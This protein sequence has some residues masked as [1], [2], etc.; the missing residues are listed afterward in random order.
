MR[1]FF[2]RTSE[3]V[4]SKQR[5]IFSSALILGLMIVVSRFFGFLRYRTL[6]G[7]F[8]KE[9]LDVFFASFRIPDLIFEVLIT[10]AFTSSFIPIFIKYQSTKEEL[11]TN[12]SAIINFILLLTFIAI[13]ILFIF[14]D[15]IIP[16]ITPGFNLQQNTQIIFYSRILLVGQLPFLIVGNILTGLGQANK[17]FLLTA[18]APIIYNVVIIF[19]TIFFAG[20]AM[21]LAPIIGVVAGGII[22]FLVQLPIFF[23]TGVHY[24]FI[25]K[26][27]TGLV[28]FFRMTIPRV[29]TVIVS[30][31][32]T[33]ID[34]TMATFLGN[35]AYTVFYLAQRLQLLPVSVIGVA[36]G[37][38]SL[39]YLSE[40][41]QEKKIDEFK[42]IIVE[43]ILNLFFFTIPIM[44][45]FIFAR[46]PIV[47]LFFGGQ[48]FDWGATVD[49][50]MCLSYF[51]VS[52]PFHTIYYF[53]TRCF[54]AILDSRTPFIF[55]SLSVAINTLLSI[56]FVLYFKLPVWSLA[57]SFSFSMIVNVFFLLLILDRRLGGFDRKL[58]LVESFKIAA[59]TL[60]S[61][62][63]IYYFMK[64]LDALVFDT[65]RTINV[66][67]LLAVGSIVYILLY[68]GLCWLVNVQE[69]YLVGKLMIKAKE[70]R[71]RIVEIYT[72][73]E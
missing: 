68:L 57:I 36:F 56:I 72:V 71:K 23:R 6:A 48:K 49:T 37:Q 22:F 46:T 9:Q 18:L 21:L 1:K 34:L 50:A 38:A 2:A 67:F 45:F 73:Y 52:L 42:K 12:I 10:G 26:K 14:M 41:F 40:I 13:G 55:S 16:A 5:T 20:S 30:Q 58:L 43:S 59:V 53:V 51:A 63:P 65:S 15:K 3:F 25:L 60:A 66:F 47:R 7:F 69:I 31:I 33:T 24:R 32:D 64:L 11:D 29:T 62:V 54:Y 35:G 8:N 44:S 39:P 27:T 17:I 19:V 70:Y 28:E 61:S 4:F